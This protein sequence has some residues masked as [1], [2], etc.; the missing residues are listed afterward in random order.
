MLR[1]LVKTVI[2]EK[3]FV[4]NKGQ[5][6]LDFQELINK[7]ILKTNGDNIKISDSLLFTQEFYKHFAKI[8]D[9]KLT[10]QFDLTV[11]F[12]KEVQDHF[13]S[14]IKITKESIQQIENL[15]CFLIIETSKRYKSSLQKYTLTLNKEDKVYSLVQ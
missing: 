3:Q 8:F 2:N 1:K 4:F 7:D 12:Y 5:I 14:E 9:F 6:P 15:L 11:K 13:Y 10:G